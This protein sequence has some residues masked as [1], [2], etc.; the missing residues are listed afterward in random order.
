MNTQ[1]LDLYVQQ[2]LYNIEKLKD[3]QSALLILDLEISTKTKS[4]TIAHYSAAK[5]EITQEILRFSEI[6]VNL[7]I[8]IYLELHC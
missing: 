1:Q 8:K 5:S 2:I 3:L 6:I 7:D 4:N